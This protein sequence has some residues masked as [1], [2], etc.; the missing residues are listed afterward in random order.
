MKSL[1]V[2]LF[3]MVF[4]SNA[5]ALKVRH[6]FDVHIGVFNASRTN[7]TYDLEDKNYS[8]KSEVKT[9]GLFDTLY[10]FKAVYS[11]A[12]KILKGVEVQTVS[13]KYNSKSRFS[14]RTKELVYNDEGIPVYQIT[15]KN[16]K[17]KKRVINQELA[18]KGT[19][20][21]QTVIAELV[22]R[23]N[24]T[25]TCAARYEI[26]DGKRRYDVI[27]KDEGVEEIEANKYSEFSGVAVKCSMY[28]DSLGSK[29]DDLLWELTSDEPVYFW[30]LETKNG[31]PFI[32]RAEMAET[33]YGKLEAYT[34]AIEVE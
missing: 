21:L 23:Y 4:S 3:V 8:V 34:R 15:S 31:V 10:P 11:T 7:F 6:E 32:A 16:D 26:F 24:K 13:Y 30:I 14:K 33:G 1:F 28:I 5:Y 20:D 22:L 2:F 25:K 17:E 9:F 12:G 27:F 29:G 18:A 19:T